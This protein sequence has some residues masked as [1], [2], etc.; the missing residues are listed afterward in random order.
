VTIENVLEN[1]PSIAAGRVRGA[2]FQQAAR[3]RL[4]EEGK[5]ALPHRSIF[6][7]RPEAVVSPDGAKP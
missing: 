3:V 7:Y 1:T 4:G 2:P 5:R 6:A